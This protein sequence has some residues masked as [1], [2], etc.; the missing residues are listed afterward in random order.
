MM[1]WP[2]WSCQRVCPRLG[3]H[4]EQGGSVCAPASLHARIIAAFPVAGTPAIITFPIPNNVTLAGLRV[5]LQGAAPQKAG[6]YLVTDAIEAT[7]RHP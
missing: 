6:C 1:G 4:L 7:L 2:S 5:T 3:G